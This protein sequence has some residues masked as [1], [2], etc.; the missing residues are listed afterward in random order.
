[1]N[2]FV[3]VTVLCAGLPAL[4]LGAEAGGLVALSDNAS[5]TPRLAAPTT[6]GRIEIEAGKSSARFEGRVAPGAPKICLFSVPAGQMV[7]IGVSSPKQDVRLAIYRAESASALG[8]AS[9]ADGTIR[10]T[11]SFSSATELR[12]VAHVETAET[13]FRFEI[14]W[15]P[16]TE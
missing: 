15:I 16:L 7:T 1:M 12:L 9:V 10:W 14:S 3:T 2:R 8:G 6:P 13:P 5:S 4:A 11:S